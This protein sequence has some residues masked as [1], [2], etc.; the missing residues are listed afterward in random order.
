MI[1]SYYKKLKKKVLRG[2]FIFD[3]V[4]GNVNTDKVTIT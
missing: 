2:H 4:S 3:T 1:Y